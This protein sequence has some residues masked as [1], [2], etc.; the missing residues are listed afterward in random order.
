MFALTEANATYAEFQVQS[1]GLGL[2]DSNYRL[3][4]QARLEEK[5]RQNLYNPELVIYSVATHCLANSIG[6][7]EGFQAYKYS[8]ALATFCLNLPKQLF[9]HLKIPKEFSIWGDRVK[10]LQELADPGFAFFTIAKQAPFYQNNISIE[11]WLQ[12]AIENAG[13]PDLDEINNLILLEM[14]E[15]KSDIVD[16]IY[17]NQLKYLLSL[18][19][20]NFAKRG[21]FGKNGLS[22][23][24]LHQNSMTLP[25]IVLGDGSTTNVAQK[26]TSDTPQGI[27]KWI[28]DIVEIEVSI[29]QFLRACRF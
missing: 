28:E 23:E 20:E 21:I 17:K 29:D 19:K 4:E 9:Y 13:L 6:I 18:G 27:E 10:A 8:S 2:L 11:E 12:K 25:P 3:V 5:F 1:Q 14:D 24:N 16:G 15:L 22:I 26:I 7:D